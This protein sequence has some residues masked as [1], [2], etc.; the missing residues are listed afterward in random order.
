MDVTGP[1]IQNKSNK[2][3]IFFYKMHHIYIYLYI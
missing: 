1:E 3:I 2:I